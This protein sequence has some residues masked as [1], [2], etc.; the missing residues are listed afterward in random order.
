M[1]A[2]EKTKKA[3]TTQQPCDLCR[4]AK[5]LHQP[6]LIDHAE[7]IIALARSTSKAFKV[8]ARNADESTPLHIACYHGS[9]DAAK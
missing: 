2:F 5:S 4:S 9:T 3:M 7:C 6:A 1:K 8:D